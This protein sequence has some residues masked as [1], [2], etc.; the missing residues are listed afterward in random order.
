M[1][2]LFNIDG[3]AGMEGRPAFEIYRHRVAG[4]TPLTLV[5]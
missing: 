5:D 2:L 4:L 1:C 3:L